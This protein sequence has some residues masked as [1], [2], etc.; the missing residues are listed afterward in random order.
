ME[1]YINVKMYGLKAVCF[2]RFFI[3]DSLGIFFFFCFANTL[4]NY[5]V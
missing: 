5:K 1:T 3:K 4:F 2:K